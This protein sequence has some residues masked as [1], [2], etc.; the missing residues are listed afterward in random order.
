MLRQLG[1]DYDD[2]GV[3][4]DIDE[5]DDDDDDEDVWRVSSGESSGS[6]GMVD[7]DQTDDEEIESASGRGCVG[8][9]CDDEFEPVGRKPEAGETSNTTPQ[10]EG[11]L[12]KQNFPYFI[13]VVPY[14]LLERRSKITFTVN[15]P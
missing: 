6:F 4:E 13:A 3:D 9:D 11:V 12:S 2:D 10:P 7:P 8:G 1:A 5:A 15:I 14:D